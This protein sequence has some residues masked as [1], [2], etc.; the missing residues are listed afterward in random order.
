MSINNHPQAGDLAV[1]QGTVKALQ[2][3]RCEVGARTFTGKCAFAVFRL[4]DGRVVERVIKLGNLK[5][6]GG[7]GNR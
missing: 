7:G 6:V 4:G 5:K 3:L 1:Y 2:G